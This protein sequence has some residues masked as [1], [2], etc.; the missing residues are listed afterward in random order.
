[1]GARTE[2][3]AGWGS[4]EREWKTAD[5]SRRALAAYEDLSTVIVM[6][7]RG[8]IPARVVDSFM[9]LIRPPNAKTTQ[10]FIA[11]MEVGA[12]YNQAIGMILEH[13]ELST[14]R[15]ILTIEEDNLI[16][17]TALLDLQREM[18]RGK[19]DV[20]GGL[21]WTKGETGVPQIWGDPSDPVYNF[22]PIPPQP[23]KVVRTNGT[24]MGCTLYRTDVFTRHP[25]PWFMTQAD[26]AGA[27]TQDLWS[28]NRWHHAGVKLKIG[29]DC[30]V[31]VGHLDVETGRV[32]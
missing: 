18:I 31:K 11:G 32:W 27:F 28:F 1:M 6:P 9:S 4:T 29:V 13:P 20:L 5:R 7:T 26:T 3:I 2:I 16:P 19:W 30:R 14:W 8:M 21:Y 12:A 23:G 22:R 10:L 24:G 17:P 15:Y 25:G